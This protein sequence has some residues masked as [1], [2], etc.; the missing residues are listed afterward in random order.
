MSQKKKTFEAAM[1]RLE[2]IAG[3]LDSGNVKLEE[4]MAL[5]SEASELSA[6]CKEQLDAAEQKISQ[7]KETTDGGIAEKKINVIEEK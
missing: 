6:F 2:E 4:S 7:L 1:T 5:F 3:L